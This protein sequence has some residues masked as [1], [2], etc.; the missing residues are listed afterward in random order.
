MIRK[1]LVSA[2]RRLAALTTVGAVAVLVYGCSTISIPMQSDLV[3]HS[4]SGSE[5]F[6]IGV[7]SRCIELNCRRLDIAEEADQTQALDP[8]RISI[9]NWN[10]YKGQRDSWSADFR[11]FA[12][13]QDIIIIQ[14]AMMHPDLAVSLMAQDYNW[15]LNP[16]FYYKDVATGV[17]TASRVKAVGKSGLRTTEPL[18]RLPKATLI[19][20]YKLRGTTRQLLVANIHS[21]NFTL[22]RKAYAAQIRALQAE[23]EKHDGPIIL[24]GDFNSWSDKRQRIVQRMIDELALRSLSYDSHNRTR[25]FGRE[26]DHVFYRG[27]EPVTVKT[28]EVTSSDHNPIMVTFRLPRNESTL[29]LG[30]TLPQNAFKGGK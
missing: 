29:A 22:G 16:G 5:S 28:H 19:S 18:L 1:S 13:D 15:N 3:H 24:A 27:L 23:L 30:K 4:S 12:R 9:L 6:S 25:V 8:D 7:I 20:Y 26:I 14:E 17:L 11:R 10:I 2:L 21:I